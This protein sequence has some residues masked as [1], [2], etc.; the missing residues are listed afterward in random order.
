MLETHNIQLQ[1]QKVEHLKQL[2]KERGLN[3]NRNKC[4]FI[5]RLL[6]D[7]DD[8]QHVSADNLSCISEAEGVNKLNN[9]HTD[10]E[11]VASGMS[12]IASGKS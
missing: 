6:Q 9:A 12:H 2:L 7:D 3:F 5:E 11:V 10:N 4:K 8:V 1:T